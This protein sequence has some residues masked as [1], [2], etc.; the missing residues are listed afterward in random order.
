MTSQQQ[1]ATASAAAAAASAAAVSTPPLPAWAASPPPPPPTAE[2]MEA[3][4]TPVPGM[5][6]WRYVGPPLEAGPLPAVVYFGL[7]AAE[8]LGGAPFDAFPRALVPYPAPC[9]GGVAVH[10]VGPTA[11]V[12]GDDTGAE[13]V[14]AGGLRV[15]SVTLPAHG[16]TAQNITA[17][18]NWAAAYAR[19]TPVVGGFVAR[20]AA[21]LATLTEEGVITPGRLVAAGVSRGGLVA[22]LLGAT[23]GVA[24]VVAFA[25]VT[26]LGD[27]PAFRGDA[28][29]GGSPPRPS[30]A[31]AP[32][33]SA[34][35][36]TAAAAAA[37]ASATTAT[38]AAAPAS[39]PAVAADAV[40]GNVA[41]IGALATK[42]V[43]YYMGN[44]DVL[45]RTRGAFEVVEALADAAHAAGVRSPPA[46]LICY[47]SIGKDGHGTPVD[48]LHDG[49][50]WVRSTLQL[51][52]RRGGRDAPSV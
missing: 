35:G 8:T 6:G 42:P 41:A 7:G 45:V 13:L 21:N 25:P 2:A 26:W 29:A 32:G 48:I 4:S 27:L 12:G 18:D 9:A 30:P 52:A 1:P 40:A 37:T 31:V 3:A 10:A 20:V 46:E 34:A 17:L 5:R 15:F 36:A 38:A 11:G 33:A 16:T 44:R 49:A 39:L 51:G 19:G 47:C 14:A 22:S 28:P 50:A 43:R 23:P 24:A